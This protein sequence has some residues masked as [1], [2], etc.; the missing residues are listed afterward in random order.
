VSHDR[1][2]EAMELGTKQ[3]LIAVQWHPEKTPNDRYTRKLFE[4]LVSA[5]K[6]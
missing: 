5:S 1:V 2:I 6:K 4:A 3:F